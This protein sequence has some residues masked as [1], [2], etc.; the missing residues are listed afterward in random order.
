MSTALGIEVTVLGLVTVFVVLLLLEIL[1]GLLGRWFGSPPVSREEGG[2]KEEL[3]RIPQELIAVITA[4]L[5]AAQE[6]EEPLELVVLPQP[7][8]RSWVQAGRQ[9]ILSGRQLRNR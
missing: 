2:E 5:V 7:P 6:P 4:A 8:P 1:I 9:E 3:P